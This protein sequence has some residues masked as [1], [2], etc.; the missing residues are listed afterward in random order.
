MNDDPF[1]R[2]LRALSAGL[3]R[4]DPT[5]AWKAEILA[6]AQR[7]AATQLPVGLGPP[8]WLMLSWATAWAAIV[9]L[10]VTAPQEGITRDGPETAQVQQPRTAPDSPNERTTLLAYEQRLQRILD[11]P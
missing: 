9:L 7:E 8:R 10:Y 2:Q 4:P 1:E 6:R 5:P 3:R 11:L